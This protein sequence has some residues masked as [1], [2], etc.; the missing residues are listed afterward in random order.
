MSRL[1]D[2]DLTLA[3]LTS[4][5]PFGCSSHRGVKRMRPG[6]RRPGGERRRM[7]IMARGAHL[8]V[9][10]TEGPLPIAAG[11][12]MNSCFPVPVRRPVT[13][14]AK[15]GALD[16]FQMSAVAGLQ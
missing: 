9:D 12:T 10:G 13:A 7:R 11:S 8:A 5:G 15:G 6:R 2:S 16:D 3:S 14:A 4:I 1:L